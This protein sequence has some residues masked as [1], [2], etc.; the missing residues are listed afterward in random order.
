MVVRPEWSCS[1]AALI[2]GSG[3]HTHPKPTGG[4]FSRQMVQET[5]QAQIEQCTH[6]SRP[7]DRDNPCR[8]MAPL[9]RVLLTGTRSAESIMASGY[10]KCRKNRSVQRVAPTSS[11]E[12]IRLPL[13]R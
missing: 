13:P 12:K 11:A 1:L 8:A 4:I 3:Q 9:K 10:V 7:K 6:A 2:K 5:G